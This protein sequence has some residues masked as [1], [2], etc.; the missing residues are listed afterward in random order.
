MPTGFNLSWYFLPGAFGDGAFGRPFGTAS[1]LVS[2]FH[3]TTMYHS[4][5][6]VLLWRDCA[7]RTT[8]RQ[9]ARATRQSTHP[10]LVATAS[11]PKALRRHHALHNRISPLFSDSCARPATATPDQSLT[12]K[13]TQVSRSRQRNLPILAAFSRYAHKTPLCMPAAAG[14]AIH[15]FLRPSTHTK[16]GQFLVLNAKRTQFLNQ[17]DGPSHDLPTITRGRV[18]RAKGDGVFFH[19][20]SGGDRG[21]G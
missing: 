8:L 1:E 3:S 7:F 12:L 5:R 20:R 10:D 15:H 4:G 17:P 19:R 13:P 21:Q 2:L 11:L 16:L 9:S 18:L 14:Q 6:V